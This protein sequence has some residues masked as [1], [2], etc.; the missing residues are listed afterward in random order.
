VI[1]GLGAWP[2]VKS[3]TL[4]PFSLGGKTALRNG[5]ATILGKI[6]EMIKHRVKKINADGLLTFRVFKVESEFLFQ[7]IF[8]CKSNKSIN[9]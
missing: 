1:F 9:S 7:T 8:G 2:E 6:I 5:V 3:K 4:Q